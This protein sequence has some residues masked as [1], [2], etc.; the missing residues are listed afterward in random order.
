MK[1]NNILKLSLAA[2]ACMTLATSAQATLKSEKV[3]LK[4]NMQVKFNKLPS[5][6]D[7]IKEAFTEGMFYGRLRAN[8]FYWDWDDEPSAG[9]DNRNMGIGA[10]LIYKTAPLHGL[11]GTIEIGRAHV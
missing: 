11:S 4:G 2:I 10:T 9:K 8:T 1:N 7:T 5:S 3:T 6:V